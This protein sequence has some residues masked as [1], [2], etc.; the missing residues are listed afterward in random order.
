MRPALGSA[1]EASHMR[2]LPVGWGPSGLGVMI[3]SDNHEVSFKYIDYVSG[4][5]G[6]GLQQVC[7]WL[8]INNLQQEPR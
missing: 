1:A 5:R 4:V 6:H 2:R 3:G 8:E 7:C